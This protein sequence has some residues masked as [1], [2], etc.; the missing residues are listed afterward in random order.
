MLRKIALALLVVGLLPIALPK[1]FAAEPKYGFVDIGKVFD[2][3]EKTKKFDQDLQEEGKKK[4]QER[5]AMVLEVR[6]LREE[7]AIL[8]EEKKKDSEASIEKKLKELD[9]FDRNV[10]KEL[11]E[12][13][14]K[15]VKEIFQDI[16]Q[17]LKLFGDR[18][19]YDYIFN[20]RALVYRNAKYDQ[21]AEVLKE[22]NNDYKK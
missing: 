7:Q 20:D 10:R 17:K 14:E 21:T 9:E 5:D 1:A 22:L 4:Q 15:V 12:K 16:D 6:K 19:G 3:Y 11:G 2:D 8:S 18:K 13:R